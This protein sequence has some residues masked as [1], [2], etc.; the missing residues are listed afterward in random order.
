MLVDTEYSSITTSLVASTIDKHYLG[1]AL[2]GQYLFDYFYKEIACEHAVSPMVS[3]T[4]NLLMLE[5]TMS[6]SYVIDN[7]IGVLQKS[8]RFCS[9]KTNTLQYRLTLM[10]R[11]SI[12]KVHYDAVLDFGDYGRLKIVISILV[13]SLLK[14]TWIY[15][16][17]ISFVK[18][19]Y[20]YHKEFGKLFRISNTVAREALEQYPEFSEKMELLHIIINSGLI[21]KKSSSPISNS[22]HKGWNKILRIER[23]VSQKGI[24]LAIRTAN[25]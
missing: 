20:S 19:S 17:N 7:I 14:A 3:K 8:L 2:A 22:R 24:D 12:L 21:I 1:V 5:T 10:Q 11:G 6:K 25:Y 9:T 4:F 13:S 18:D 16:E 15:N 23:L